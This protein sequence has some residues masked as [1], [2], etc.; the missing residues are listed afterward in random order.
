MA[1]YI[2]T[3]RN[4]KSCEPHCGLCPRGKEEQQAEESTEETS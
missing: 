2:C 1:C 4:E 3:M